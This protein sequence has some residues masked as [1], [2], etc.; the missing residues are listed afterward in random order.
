MHSEALLPVVL[1]GANAC[2]ERL[3]GNPAAQVRL[4]VELDLGVH[5]GLPG[6]FFEVAEGDVV[7]VLLGPQHGDRVVEGFQKRSQRIE[8]KSGLEVLDAVVR[9]CHAVAGGDA[10]RHGRLHG[11]LEVHVQ[12]GFGHAVDERFQCRPAP[13]AASCTDGRNRQHGQETAGTERCGLHE[14]AA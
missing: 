4:R 5:D 6:A 7:E 9:C 14:P 11:A 3:E 1:S 13:F 12:F 8:A 2:H 10:Q